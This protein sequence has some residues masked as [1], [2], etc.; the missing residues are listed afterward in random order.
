DARRHRPRLSRT[1][2]REPARARRLA[3]ARRCGRLR[4]EPVRAAGVAARSRGRGALP[5]G[6]AAVALPARAGRA[7]RA[8]RGR[9]P[10]GVSTRSCVVPAGRLTGPRPPRVRGERIGSTVRSVARP[11]IESYHERPVPN[12]LH[13]PR[14]PASL[15]TM[16]HTYRLLRRLL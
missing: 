2:L 12:Q 7:R 5:R 16:T 14:L 11:H 13:W 10:P 9:R 8:A 15:R 3:A 4:A 6:R 1:P